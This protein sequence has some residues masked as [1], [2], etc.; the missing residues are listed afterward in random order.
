MKILESVFFGDAGSLAFEVFKSKHPE[1]FHVDI[2]ARN[3]S[4]VFSP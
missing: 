2:G 4:P 1:K 3:G